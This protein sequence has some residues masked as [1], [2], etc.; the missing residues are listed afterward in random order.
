MKNNLQER[1]LIPK[2][3]RL[4]PKLNSTF[5]NTFEG[6]KIGMGVVHDLMSRYPA[7]KPIALA[8]DAFFN[9]SVSSIAQRKSFG[10]AVAEWSGGIAAGAVCTI[11]T[12]GLVVNLNL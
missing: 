5:D 1:S 4:V 10:K 6:M 8:N 12:D 7:Y 2:E 9:I 11:G 3:D